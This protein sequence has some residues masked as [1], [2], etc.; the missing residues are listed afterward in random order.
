M[1]NM[2]FNK[3]LFAVILTY[4]HLS[5]LFGCGGGD[6]DV[7]TTS[8][9]TLSGQVTFAG[10]ALSCVTVNLSGRSLVFGRHRSHRLL[11]LHRPLK[12]RLTLTLRRTTARAFTPA[13]VTVA[14]K[15]RYPD[16]HRRGHYRGSGRKIFPRLLSNGGM[17]AQR[18]RRTQATGQR[19]IAPLPVRWGGSEKLKSMR[20]AGPVTR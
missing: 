4:R 6:D 16:V 3:V 18:G 5:G 12:R 19:R 15:R 9:H 14:G 7:T 17:G 10:P 13:S 8:T 2:S 11:Q 1:N 20:S